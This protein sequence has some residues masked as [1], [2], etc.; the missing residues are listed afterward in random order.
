MLL[1]WDFLI[2][3][4]LCIWI[5]SS[6][7]I[8]SA[9]LLWCLPDAIYKTFSYRLN[10]RKLSPLGTQNLGDIPKNPSSSIRH[11]Q[12]TIYNFL[13]ICSC[14]QLSG[15][16]WIRHTAHA[17]MKTKRRILC[18]ELRFCCHL[19]FFPPGKCQ[20]ATD[21][22]AIWTGFKSCVSVYLIPLCDWTQ[23]GTGTASLKSQAWHIDGERNSNTTII[24]YPS[25]QMDVKR[26][27]EYDPL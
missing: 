25:T 20:N 16:L 26:L 12:H 14:F 3:A 17:I 11:V 2:Q 1:P 4:H 8:R 18:L 10:S 6:L 9:A 27:C 7:F 19:I 13:N 23:L 21:L 22:C 15:S 5:C 24:P